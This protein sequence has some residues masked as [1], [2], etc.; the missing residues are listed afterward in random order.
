MRTAH[1]RHADLLR[2]AQEGFDPARLPQL[3]GVGDTVT[4]QPTKPGCGER[5]RGGSDRGFLRL[6]QD[7]GRQFG[8]DNVVLFVDSSHGEVGRP[9]LGEGISDPADPLTLHDHFAGG[10]RHYTDLFTRLAAAL[11][12]GGAAQRF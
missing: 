8:T 1:R 4:S 3:V 12:A 2:L 9:G 10:H 11:S 6:V 5:L 7:L